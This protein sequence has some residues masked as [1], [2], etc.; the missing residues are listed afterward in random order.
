MTQPPPPAALPPGLVDEL[1][2][3]ITA[4]LRDGET[5]ATGFAR[6]EAELRGAFAAV[7]IVESLAL[8]ARLVN[9]RPE[10]PLATAFARL[11]ADRRLRLVE[12]L[13][14]ARRRAARYGARG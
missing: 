13:A 14:D 6:K 7:G 9:P 3:I 8:H 11:T 4:P 10:D 5:A 1:I 2:A 12:F